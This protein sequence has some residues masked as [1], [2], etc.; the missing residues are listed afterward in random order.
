MIFSNVFCILLIISS[1]SIKILRQTAAINN[2]NLRARGLFT[3][4]NLGVKFTEAD[5][6]QE[7]ILCLVKKEMY[8]LETN[9]CFFIHLGKSFYYV[10]VYTTRL[11]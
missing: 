9:R 10:R 2:L 7:T 1:K 6:Q 8:C 11:Y 4:T 5:A 3:I